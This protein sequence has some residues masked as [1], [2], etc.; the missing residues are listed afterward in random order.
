ML[1]RRLDTP[2]L[3]LD[4]T[5]AAHADGLWEATRHS[6]P[7]LLPTMSWAPAASLETSRTYATTMEQRWNQQTDWSFT[8]FFGD[9]TIGS[10]SL[11][12]YQAL[13][14]LCE[15]GYWLRSDLA[16]RGLMTEAGKAVCDFA[17]DHV[18]VHR[19]E[20]RA[21]IDN[22]GSRRVAE[23]LGFSHEGRLRE[24]GWVESGY[25]DMYLFGLLAA[26]RPWR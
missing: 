16:G 4:A 21:A 19:I 1:P 11:M 6:L 24:A 22:P 25:Q 8:M 2:R 9:E 23:K 10:I 5:V 7:E 12:R 26:E 20:L 18:G 13:F 14:S 17:F 3:R 15:L